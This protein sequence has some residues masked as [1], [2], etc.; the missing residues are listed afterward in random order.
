MRKLDCKFLNRKPTSMN[1]VDD[2]RSVVLA[3]S[4]YRHD[5]DANRNRRRCGFDVGAN[6]RLLRPAGIEARSDEAIRSERTSSRRE[7]DG[8]TERRSQSTTSFVLLTSRLPRI[9]CAGSTRSLQR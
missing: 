3:D 8:L 1:V 6:R 7:S 4:F 2:G 5:L 9:H